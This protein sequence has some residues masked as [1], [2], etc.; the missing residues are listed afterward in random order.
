MKL[1]KLFVKD[2]SKFHFGQRKL[3][4]TDVIFHNDSLFSAIM[5]N[6][7]KLYGNIPQKV[8][9]LSS[10]FHFSED[11]LFFP[12]PFIKL[13]IDLDI[14]DIKKIKFISKGV[15]DNINQK[16]ENYFINE[17]GFLFLKG[18]SAPYLKKFIEPKAFIPREPGNATPFETESFEISNGGFYFF[19]DDLDDK[20][21]IQAIHMIKNEGLG[22]KRSS[23]K[24]LFDKIEISNYDFREN[25]DRYFSLSLINPEKDDFNKIV[26]YDIIQRKGF[27]YSP[28]TK[29]GYRKKPTYM[30]VEG[31]IFEE[32]ISG[33]IKKV[34]NA[35]GDL[36]HD[37]Y[38][39]GR[40]I[41]M[42]F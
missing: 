10:V 33:T 24:G 9:R 25:K 2:G 6:Y 15:L 31:S 14:K 39:D 17:D 41:M 5:N 38:R 7:V 28:F 18:E 30:L 11:T 36:K 32:Q 1:I 26:A 3:N 40:A 12:R 27:I 16:I 34:A 13:D 20:K 29:I 23:G 42:G 4:S 37:V 35:Q 22:G 21:I 19:A 8:P